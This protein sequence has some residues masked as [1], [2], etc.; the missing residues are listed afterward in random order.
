MKRI[1]IALFVLL[2]SV[3]METL[4]EG[5]EEL[6]YKTN[7]RG[8]VV[9]LEDEKEPYTGVLTDY[10]ENEQVR[11]KGNY[12]KG[13]LGI[14]SNC[15]RANYYLFSSKTPPPTLCDSNRQ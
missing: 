1:L 13:I 2:V 9:F 14:K 3:G 12:D 6:S 11:F 15:A 10:Y 7:N 4:A 8:G 5:R